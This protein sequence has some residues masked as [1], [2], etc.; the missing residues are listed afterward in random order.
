MGKLEKEFEDMKHMLYLMYTKI[1]SKIHL[2]KYYRSNSYR[3]LKQLKNSHAGQRCFIIGNGPSLSIDDLNKLTS[4]YTFAT[5]RIFDVF[6]DTAWRPTYYLIQDLVLLSKLKKDI[7]QIEAQER[8]SPVNVRWLHRFKVPNTIEFYLNTEAFYPNL[9]KFSRDASRQIYEGYTVTYAA[10][11]LA[12]Y[13]GFKKIYLIGVDFNYSKVITAS[14]LVV[15][16][17]DVID[18]FSER[19]NDG[20]NLPNLDNSYLAYK[21]AQKFCD[22]NNV[23]IYNATRGGKLEVFKR[24]AFDSLFN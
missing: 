10:I 5:H 20:I 2:Y 6:N 3:K 18:Y 4:E 12:M 9:P 21:S 15:T 23:E 22:S 1:M 7:A 14:G 19:T 17:K 8:F 11:Q 16:N 24:V 13:M